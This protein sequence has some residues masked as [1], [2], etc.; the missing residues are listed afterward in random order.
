M[1]MVLK[2]GEQNLLSKREVMTLAVTG[3]GRYK[4]SKVCEDVLT[5]NRDDISMAM[6]DVL[7]EW[8]SS[9]RNKKDCVQSIVQSLR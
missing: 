3:L 7:I 4:T 6:H 2:L 9:Y 1:A 8:N 5:N